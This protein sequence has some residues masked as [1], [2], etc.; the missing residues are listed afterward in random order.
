MLVY[1]AAFV[2]L[3][4]PLLSMLG[5][6]FGSVLVVSLIGMAFLALNHSN[7]ATVFAEL[8]PPQVRTTGIALPYAISN[9]IFGGTAPS[10][11]SSSARA[12][13]SGRCRRSTSASAR[14]SPARSST[15]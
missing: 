5:S 11:C 2:I 9:A 7:L 12:T 3:P 14:R 13:T 15:S 1:A 4:F 6:S 10:E 8:F